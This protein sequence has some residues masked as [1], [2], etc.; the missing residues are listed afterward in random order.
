MISLTFLYITSYFRFLD[1][2]HKSLQ[3]FDIEPFHNV[4]NNLDHDLKLIFENRSKSLNLLD[5]NFQIVENN[6]VFDIYD[7]NL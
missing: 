3:Y 6:L 7:V 1:V 2:F 5:I 4:I